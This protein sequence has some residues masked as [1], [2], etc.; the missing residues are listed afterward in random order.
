MACFA[1]LSPNRAEEAGL[2]TA[3]VWFA[4]GGLQNEVDIRAR[5]AQLTCIH[6]DLG[7]HVQYLATRDDDL[8]WAGLDGHARQA[9]DFHDITALNRV[10]VHHLERVAIFEAAIVQF[11]IKRVTIM[12]YVHVQRCAGYDQEQRSCSDDRQDRTVQQY[13]GTQDRRLLTH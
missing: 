1:L 7:R 2:L 3:A 6:A 11:P 9:I 10:T 5:A 8:S 12:E 4:I 13:S